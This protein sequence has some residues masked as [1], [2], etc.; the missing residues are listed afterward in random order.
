MPL[1]EAPDLGCGAVYPFGG[2]VAAQELGVL[3]GGAS[4]WI[5]DGVGVVEDPFEVGDVGGGIGRRWWKSNNE[6]CVA[7]KV[8]AG[9]DAV[10]AFGCFGE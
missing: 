3:E 7:P 5:D 6:R 8:C 9:E 10:G 4:C 2:V 1:G